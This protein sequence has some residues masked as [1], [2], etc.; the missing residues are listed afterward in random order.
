MKKKWYI[1]IW[2]IEEYTEITFPEITLITS[3]KKIFKLLSLL[4]LVIPLLGQSWNIRISMEKFQVT[5]SEMNQ[6][7]G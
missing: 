3:F 1:S 6:N 7:Q 2:K 4:D 5:F